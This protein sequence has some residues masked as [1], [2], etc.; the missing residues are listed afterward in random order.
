LSQ[1]ADP[2]D[3]FREI[4]A[5]L[6]EFGSLGRRQVVKA[7]AVGVQAGMG[8]DLGSHLQ[9]FFGPVIAAYIVAFSEMTPDDQD[10]IRTTNEGIHHHRRVNSAGAHDPDQPDYR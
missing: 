10:T 1:K 7:E 4:I 5:I 6:R 8:Q 9:L 3:G 2:S